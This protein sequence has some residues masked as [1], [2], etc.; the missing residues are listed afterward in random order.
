MHVS[1][2]ALPTPM[3]A[4]PA[5]RGNRHMQRA[6][7]M[8]LRT[9]LAA[10]LAC[11]ALT[12]WTAEA[13]PTRAPAGHVVSRTL[14]LPARDLFEGDQLTAQAKQQLAAFVGQSAAARIE[15]AL[16]VPTGPWRA[17]ASGR[18]ER[19][20]TPARLDAVRNFLAER[21]LERR[22]L[23]VESRI[24]QRLREPRLDIEFVG[25]MADD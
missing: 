5:E 1:P 17:A 25:R 14:S 2:P 15:V 18:D 19:D 13:G 4:R 10:A 12:A 23:F 20:L 7:T 21:G 24:D 11:T 6:L 9:A 22:H 3:I 8:T 16:V